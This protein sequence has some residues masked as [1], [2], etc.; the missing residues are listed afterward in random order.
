MNS[1]SKDRSDPECYGPSAN[2]DNYDPGGDVELFPAR[3]RAKDPAVEEQDAELEKSKRE[4][5]NEIREILDLQKLSTQE[6]FDYHSRVN[7]LLKPDLLIRVR[8]QEPH[9]AW[10]IRGWENV[11]QG[12]G[13][14]TPDNKSCKYELEELEKVG[15]AKIRKSGIDYTRLHTNAG[16]VNQSSTW[17]HGSHGS[18]LIVLRA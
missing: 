14:S 13:N 9:R 6:L 5:T 8:E 11:S 15:Q 4:N 16:M 1:T 10:H 17:S 7:Y 18:L 12:S 2:H 3:P